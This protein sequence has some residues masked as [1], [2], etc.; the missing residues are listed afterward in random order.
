MEPRSD[1]PIPD[2]AKPADPRTGLAE[3]R[4]SLA[5]QRVQLALERTTL[6]W[7]RTTLT[8]VSFGLGVIGF[9]RSLRLQAQTPE[10]V[11]MHETAIQFGYGLLILGIA[12]TVLSGAAHRRALLKLEKGEMSGVAKWPLGITLAALLSLLGLWVLWSLLIR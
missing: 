9:Y 5:S 2:E 10:S 8:M 3:M 6:A 1:S 7:I 11:H 4:T 12:A